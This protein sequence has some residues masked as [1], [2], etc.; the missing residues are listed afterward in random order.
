MSNV[1]IYNNVLSNDVL[2]EIEKLI[3]KAN[4]LGEFID[5][6]I[7]GWED[8]L[9]VHDK[10]KILPLK[11]K[12]KILYNKI[13]EN[14][15]KTLHKNIKGIQLNIHGIPKNAYIPHHTDNHVDFA[16]TI[17]INRSWSFDHGGF[18]KFKENDKN[19][20]VMPKYNTMVYLKDVLHWVTPNLSDEI[21]YTVQGFYTT[22]I[23]YKNI[24][25]NDFLI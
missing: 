3:I 4:N 19:F 2:M 10:I 18:L 14:I 11:D 13:C 17:Y 22:N 25:I 1:K 7:F 23:Y 12:Y 5:N 9:V 20:K 16:I 15:S 8:D 21:R 24:P 6:D